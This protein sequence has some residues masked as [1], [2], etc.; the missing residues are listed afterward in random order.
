MVLAT[1]MALT[2]AQEQVRAV[3]VAEHFLRVVAV[4][5]VVMVVEKTGQ[6]CKVDAAAMNQAG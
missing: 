3:V 1:A 5:A 2:E 6:H 4:V